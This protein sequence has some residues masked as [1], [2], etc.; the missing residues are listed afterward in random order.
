M[1]PPP[2]R[3]AL[4]RFGGRR[5]LALRRRELPK[6]LPGPRGA[7][8]RIEGVKPNRWEDL[9]LIEFRVE[10]KIQHMWLWHLIGGGG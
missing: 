8:E 2:L 5:M 6:R 10:G 3:R 4:L 1:G 7:S 9:P